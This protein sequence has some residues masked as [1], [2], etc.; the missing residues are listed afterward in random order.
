MTETAVIP[1]TSEVQKA[2]A[3]FFVKPVNL[4]GALR[5]AMVAASTDATLP[6]LN[7]VAIT[8]TGAGNLVVQST[9]RYMLVRALLENEGDPAQEW[10]LGDLGSTPAVVSLGQCKTLLAWLKGLGRMGDKISLKVSVYADRMTLT[11]CDGTSYPVLLTDGDYPRIASLIEDK[12][13]AEGEGVNCYGLNGANLDKLGK[14]GKLCGKHGNLLIRTAD[15][16]SDTYSK[17]VHFRGGGDY[18]SVAPKFDG[19]VMPVR[20]PTADERHDRDGGL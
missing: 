1:T 6:I 14:L 13:P 10:D 8:V 12:W 17:P 9:D 18:K 3:E 11:W 20:I 7:A 16:T 4:D 2:R 15:T 5:T 19:L